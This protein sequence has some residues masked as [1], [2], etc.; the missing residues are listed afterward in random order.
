M[1]AIT[2]QYTESVMAKI[3]S[4]SQ[5]ANIDKAA[6]LFDQTVEAGHKIYFFG[7]GHSFMTGQEVFGRAGGYAGFV[8]VVENELSMTHIIKSTYI[9]RIADYA[10][11][12][13]GLYPF[14]SGDTI[15]M[16]SNSG[17]NCL[18]VELALRL[19]EK[20]LKIIAITAMNHQAEITSRHPSGKKLC[21]LADLILNNESDYGD[22]SVTHGDGT[23]TGP[24][25][26]IMDCFLIDAVVS[27]FVDL[28][29]KRHGSAPV[30]IS[31]NVDEGDAHNKALFGIK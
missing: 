15:V 17:R 4:A 18:V 21:D 30:F 13:M 8:P 24:T 25:S 27:N 7:T 12:I 29:I 14:Q 16:T 20:G 22:V 11:V 6:A 1:S 10:T 19:K 5:D 2:Q 31:S 28:Q 23:K 3:R 9:E 26:T